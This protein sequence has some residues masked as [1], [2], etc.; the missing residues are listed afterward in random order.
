MSSDRTPA[1]FLNAILHGDDPPCETACT[2]VI[3]DGWTALG[4]ANVVG[5]RVAAAGGG[6]P[7]R[8]RCPEHGEMTRFMVHDRP[9]QIACFLCGLTPLDLLDAA[10][11][12]AGGGVPEALTDV[13]TNPPAPELLDRYRS[14][15]AA[16]DALFG[17][18]V[19]EGGATDE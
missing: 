15:R 18:G 5:R 17:G 7:E 10:P 19:P 11:V 8:P 6:V 3:A 9:V 2:H 16:T 4:M 12:A 1:D 14:D 13:F